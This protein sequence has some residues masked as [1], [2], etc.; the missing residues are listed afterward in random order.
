MNTVEREIVEAGGK[1]IAITVDV[2]DFEDIERMVQK[3][4]DV[5]ALPNYGMVIAHAKP[6]RTRPTDA[7]MYSSI[8]QAP[9]GGQRWKRPI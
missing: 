5:S 4:V 2:R 1:A 7:L 9:Y 3:V 6:K 8:I